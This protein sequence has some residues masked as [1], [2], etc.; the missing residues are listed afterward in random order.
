MYSDSSWP[1]YKVN[2][3]STAENVYRYAEE[4]FERCKLQSVVTISKSK[5][6]NFGFGASAQEGAW[7][8]RMSAFSKRW[9]NILILL[10]DGDTQASIQIAN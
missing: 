1:G 9:L 2:K 8:S 5:T 3:K 6:Q 7:H 4:L 10:I